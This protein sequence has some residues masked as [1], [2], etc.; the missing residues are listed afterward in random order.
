MCGARKKKETARRQKAGLGGG[1][2]YIKAA[3]VPH[4]GLLGILQWSGAASE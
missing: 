2:T 1:L 3:G 4:Y